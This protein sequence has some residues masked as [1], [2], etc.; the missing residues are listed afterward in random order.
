MRTLFK[1]AAFTG[2]SVLVWLVVVVSLTIVA[3]I[4]TTILRHG[5]GGSF[6]PTVWVEG[7]PYSSDP[8]DY[9][10]FS[11]HVVFRS[12]FGSLVTQYRV[13]AFTGIIS[14]SWSVSTDFKIWTFKLRKGLNFD[15]HDKITPE[16]IF[17]SLNR[18]AFMLKKRGSEAGLFE[19]LM[20][21]EKLSS[22]DSEWPGMR[23]DGENLVFTFKRPFK[24]MLETVGFGLY[25]IVHPS[26]FDNSTGEWLDKRRVI[27]SGA[28]SVAEWGPDKLILRERPEYLPDFRKT[29]P[30]RRIQ[31]RWDI[32]SRTTSD[33]L[34]GTSDETSFIGTHTFFG[35]VVS[36]I[37]YVQCMSWTDPNSPCFDLAKRKTLRTAFYNSMR[38]HGFS[39]TLSFFPVTMKGIHELSES[40]DSIA[41]QFHGRLRFRPSAFGNPIFRSGYNLAVSDFC[42]K[43]GFDCIEVA[44]PYE[45]LLMES[46]P[47]TLSFSA[48]VAARGTGILVE[49]PRQDIRFMFLSK[50]GIKLP[51][52][53]GR[54]FR[55]LES[56]TFDPQKINAL[57]WEQA[58]IWPL[59]H[60]A[61]GLW[62][63][64]DEFDFSEINLILPPTDFQWIGFK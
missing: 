20:G 49:D 19:F 9:D 61:S 31:I 24:K 14:E 17:K 42:T 11:H 16:V 25:S 12:V 37:G 51:D 64:K 8:L 46:D 27:S 13:G 48:D 18:V 32:G 29:H 6:E 62:V 43:L 59:C 55:E 33:I 63:K 23:L 3:A 53:D 52:T 4:M 35:G 5:N 60:Y 22:P 36:E 45:E 10:L 21:Y 28:Y 50:E 7:A 44:L 58:V 2:R 40:K 56:E 39:P 30:L 54:I 1:D 47:K 26:L 15:N 57:L 41:E 38:N 34:M